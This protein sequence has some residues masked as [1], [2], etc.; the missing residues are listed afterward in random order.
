MKNLRKENFQEYD[1]ANDNVYMSTEMIDFFSNKLMEMKQEFL[2]K[3]QE[4]EKAIQ[5]SAD[6]TAEPIDSAQEQTR[7]ENEILPTIEFER[8]LLKKIEHAFERIQS[9]EYG[10]CEKSGEPIGVARLQAVPTATMCIEVQKEEEEKNTV[11]HFSK[12]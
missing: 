3:E 9:G 10:Y 8:N 6:K 5:E 11:H 1:P 4:A 12:A 7:L 2:K